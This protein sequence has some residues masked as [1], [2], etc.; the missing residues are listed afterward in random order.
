MWPHLHWLLRLSSPVCSIAAPLFGFNV[1]L[2]KVR[3]YCVFKKDVRALCTSGARFL[4]LSS[5]C[6]TRSQAAFVAPSC[7]SSPFGLFGACKFISISVKNL[8]RTSRVAAIHSFWLIHNMWME[9]IWF[10]KVNGKTNISRALT[11]ASS[12]LP[13][14]RKTGLELNELF[15]DVDQAQL[16]GPLLC[17]G[18]VSTFAVD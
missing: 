3:T 1:A 13:V 6:A 11:K 16:L 8:K 9:N 12:D 4:F 17:L 5:Y 15:H 2:V 14:Y 7:A 10:A 18:C